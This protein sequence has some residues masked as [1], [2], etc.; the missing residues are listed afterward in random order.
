[1]FSLMDLVAPIGI[2]LLSAVLCIWGFVKAKEKPA[3]VVCVLTGLV[4]L[5]SNP[6]LYLMRYASRKADYT[7]QQ[8]VRVRQGEK[9]KCE[10]AYVTEN[11]QWVLDWW[12]KH[13]P[14]KAAKVVA[15]VDDRLLV[16]LDEEKLGAAGRWMRGYTW[17]NATVVG[18]N[19]KQEYTTSLIR[20]ELSHTAA[21]GCGYPLDEEAQHKLFKDLKLGY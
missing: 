15:S 5:G 16:C 12:S 2:S 6:A 11:V 8:G 18:W 13:C 9:N 17:G 7:T 1:M 4:F 14:D 3:K 20:H 10:K 21:T 19:G